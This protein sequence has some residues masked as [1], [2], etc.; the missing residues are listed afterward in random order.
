MTAGPPPPIAFTTESINN[1][2]VTAGQAATV[3][4]VLSID[5]TPMVTPQTTPTVFVR[6]R[7]G[8]T[9][10]ESG[11]KSYWFAMRT[12]LSESGFDVQYIWDCNNPYEGTT[13][14]LGIPG[15]FINGELGIDSNAES[16]TNYICQKAVQYK[17]THYGYYPK[18]INIVA[19]MDPKIRTVS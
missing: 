17:N 1:V 4:F 10:W 2:V 7:G 13:N 8:K 18:Q 19:V 5:H 6:G 3:N 12:K 16:L 11:E 9:Y 15:E 14:S